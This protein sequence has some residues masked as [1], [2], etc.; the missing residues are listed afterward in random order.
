MAAVCYLGFL[1]TWFWA[2]GRIGL[3]FS[4]ILPN[5]VQREAEIT[6]QYRNPWWRPSAILDLLRHH[7]GPPTK[8][9]SLGHI[10]VWNFMLIWCIVLKIWRFEF[11]ADLAWNALSRVQNFGFFGES[12]PLNVIGHHRE[13]QKA[14]P[15]SKSHLHANFG[16]DRSIGATWVRA[17]GIKKKKKKKRKKQGK[18]LY[19]APFCHWLWPVAYITACTT[20]QAVMKVKWQCLSH[21]WIVTISH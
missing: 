4:I 10:G 17:E 11:F 18:K 12:E 9:F 16:A 8:S 14:H 2:I 5:L 3:C 1:I 15:W 13:P 7:S 6:A 20:V 21:P 19:P